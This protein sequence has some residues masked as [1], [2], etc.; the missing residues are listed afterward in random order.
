MNVQKKRM[1]VI[2]E[3]ILREIKSCCFSHQGSY[4]KGGLYKADSGTYSISA[5]SHVLFGIV[6]V[7]D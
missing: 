6:V 1:C 4:L 3:L 7:L 5:G 2:A